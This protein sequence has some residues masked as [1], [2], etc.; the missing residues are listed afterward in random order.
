MI[1][2]DRLH[3]WQAYVLQLV[4]FVQCFTVYSDYQIWSGIGLYDVNSRLSAVPISFCDCGKTTGKINLT[5]DWHSTSCYRRPSTTYFTICWWY[6]V[7]YLKSYWIY[8]AFNHFHYKIQENISE[9]MPASSNISKDVRSTP[10]K[11]AENSFT[12]PRAI[13]TKIPKDLL[14]VN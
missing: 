11:L 1:L 5:T 13:T 3:A 7:I 2:P 14:R 4:S 6:S 8:S 9:L 12:Y 10:F